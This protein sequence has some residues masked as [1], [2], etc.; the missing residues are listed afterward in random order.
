M[1]A[2]WVQETGLAGY[3]G[4]DRLYVA[5]R[6]NVAPVTST[7]HPAIRYGSIRLERASNGLLLPPRV[8]VLY[9]ICIL[10]SFSLFCFVVMWQPRLQ[11]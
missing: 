6:C 3:D 10:A 7:A 2:V 9:F 5:T 11:F 8:F 1:A 4:K